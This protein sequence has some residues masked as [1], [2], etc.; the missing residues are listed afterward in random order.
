MVWRTHNYYGPSKQERQRA[1]EAVLVEGKS[2]ATAG[3]GRFLRERLVSDPVRF[4]A[5]YTMA[6]L[7]LDYEVSRDA[8][9]EYVRQLGTN[10][11]AKDMI[12]LSR[13]IAYPATP[14]KNAQYI[15]GEDIAGLAMDV[16]ERRGDRK[17]LSALLDLG[18]R[19][20]GCLA[21]TLGVIYAKLAKESPR[22]LLETL[23]PKR[24]QV[25]SSVSGLI[26]Y[27]LIEAKSA[28]RA[29]PKVAALAQDSKDPLRE[30]AARLLRVVN[31]AR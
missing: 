29:L 21:E 10:E 16:C 20:D 9:L 12:Q 19:S 6:L 28:E 22:A 24:A 14:E 26:A 15:L 2:A 11:P 1:E 18:P 23:R 3:L 17:I 4:Q 30:S 27:N 31:G 5:V 13:T 7:D 25:W 8:L